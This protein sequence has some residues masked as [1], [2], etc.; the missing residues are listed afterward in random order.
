MHLVHASK[1]ALY[2]AFNRA[3]ES[4]R[5]ADERLFYDPYAKAFLPR[6]LKFVLWLHRLPFFNW[7]VY[8][9]IEKLYPGTL[10]SGAARTR[11]IDVMTV[12]TIE[13]HGVNQV[14]I[15]GA[16]FDCRAHRL[17]EVK[18]QFVEVDHPLAQK[19][20]QAV[21]AALPY[22]RRPVDYVPMDMA[23]QQPDEVIPR[24]LQR[25]HYR[26]LFIWEGVSNSLTG[27]TG[28]KMFRYFAGFPPGTRI[29]FTYVDKQVLEN[30]GMFIGAASMTR[31]LKKSNDNWSF[32]LDPAGIRDFLAG[33]DMELEED[34]G[35]TEYRKLYFG[36]RAGK[37][38]G[39]EW[40]RVAMAR[41]KAKNNDHDTGCS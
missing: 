19:A 20:K 8:W 28:D 24:L 5:P 12:R 23:I 38:K 25:P 18:A 6:S 16:E 39:Y 40:Y 29:I 26:T 13:R 15:L 2:K 36:K 30:P 1:M 10:T 27:A 4:N 35:T 11:L 9:Y 7:F 21:L 14:V 22:Q 34:I 41:V 3:I 37:M 33:Y 31:L 32:G 17:Q